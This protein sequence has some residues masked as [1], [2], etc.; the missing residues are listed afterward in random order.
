[1]EAFI[2]C[3][4]WEFEGLDAE[5]E[6]LENYSYPILGNRKVKG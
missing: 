6:S 1:M 4:E 3:L 5:V 2:L